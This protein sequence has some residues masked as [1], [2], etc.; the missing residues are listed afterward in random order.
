MK[1]LRMKRRLMMTEKSDRPQRQIGTHR[2]ITNDGRD[3]MVG[4]RRNQPVNNGK[5]NAGVPRSPKEKG[6]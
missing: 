5:M 1:T 6:K 4:D 2:A 3:R